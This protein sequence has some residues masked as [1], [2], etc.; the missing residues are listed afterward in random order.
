[1]KLPPEINDSGDGM[2]GLVLALLVSGVFYAAIG[3]YLI[4]R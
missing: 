4:F 2:R 3:L 1:M